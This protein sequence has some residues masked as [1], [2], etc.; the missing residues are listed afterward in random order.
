MNMS[1][2]KMTI[3]PSKFEFRGANFVLLLLIERRKK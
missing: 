2:T 3:Y 1:G